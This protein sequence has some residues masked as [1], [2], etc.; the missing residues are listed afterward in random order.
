MG[1]IS[2]KRYNRFRLSENRLIEQNFIF[3][4]GNDTEYVRK[5]CKETI[6]RSCP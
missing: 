3:M 4:R 2:M 5:I 1:R 6:A